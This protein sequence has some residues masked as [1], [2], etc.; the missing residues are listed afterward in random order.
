MHTEEMEDMQ[1]RVSNCITVALHVYR[2]AVTLDHDLSWTE[3]GARRQDK[4][5]KVKSIYL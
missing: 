4:V 1:M 3:G 5:K 2:G